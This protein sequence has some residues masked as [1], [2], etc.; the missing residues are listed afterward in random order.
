MDPR[1]V[2][3]HSDAAMDYDSQ[4]TGGIGY[5]IEFPSNLDIKL[6][7]GYENH[8]NQNIERLEM[9]GIITGIEKFQKYY[10]LNSGKLKE[11]KTVIITTDR[12]KLSDTEL[13]NPYKIREYRSRGWKNHEGK[14]IKNE[15]LLDKIDK[16]KTKLSKTIRG[17]VRIN[18]IREKKNRVA[19][20]L[21]RLGKTAIPSKRVVRT[22]IQKLNKRI[23]N[24]PDVNYNNLNV[25]EKILIRPYLKEPVGKEHEISAEICDGEYQGRK[26]KI[27]IDKD[28][29]KKLKRANMYLI[30]IENIYTHHIRIGENIEN[31]D[32]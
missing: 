5:W 13:T 25:G 3:I 27:Y 7:E 28:L 20:K 9:I 32:K 17:G 16:L 30:Q 19:D 23:F 14:P 29:E 10:E 22:K 8:N 6:V 21:S 4:N 12:F 26:I 18:Y 11:V 24:N 1:A 15:D 31:L 2:Y